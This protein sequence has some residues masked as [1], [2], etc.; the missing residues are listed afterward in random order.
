MQKTDLEQALDESTPTERLQELVQE[1]YQI[2]YL[3]NNADAICKA[4]AHN[5]NASK[6]LLK[7]LFRPYPVRVLNNPALDLLILENPNFINELFE[8]VG[9]NLYYDDDNEDLFALDEWAASHQLKTRS[10][11]SN[12]AMGGK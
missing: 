9:T 4:V 7:K 1:V 5:P 6:E 8:S 10:D 12:E 2:K 3:G 11:C